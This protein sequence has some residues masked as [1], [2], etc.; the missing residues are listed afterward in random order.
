MRTPSENDLMSF[1]EPMSDK[2]EWHEAFVYQQ[3]GDTR[4]GP[5]KEGGGFAIWVMRFNTL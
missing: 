4:N 5:H 3:K 1:F 2:R